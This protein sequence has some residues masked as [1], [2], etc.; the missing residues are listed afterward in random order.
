VIVNNGQPKKT[1][2]RYS[3]TLRSKTLSFTYYCIEYTSTLYAC[4]VNCENYFFIF[5]LIFRLQKSPIP[6]RGN[7]ALGGAIFGRLYHMTKIA[8]FIGAYLASLS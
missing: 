4:Q 3:F 6:M 7:R 1:Q 5:S 8:L 2:G